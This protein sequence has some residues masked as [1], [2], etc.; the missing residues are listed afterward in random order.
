VAKE[1]NDM[2]ALAL[3][4]YFAGFL[5]YFEHNHAEMERLASDLIEMSTR[6]TF[7]TFLSVG[8]IL[9]GSAR[10][11]SGDST[12]G[13]SWIENGIADYRPSGS[14]LSMPYFLA[15]KAEALHLADRSSVALEAVS[16]AEAMVERR[17]RHAPKQPTQNTAGKKRAGQEDVDPDYHCGDCLQRCTYGSRVSVGVPANFVSKRGPPGSVVSGNTRSL[18]QRTTICQTLCGPISHHSVRVGLPDVAAEGQLGI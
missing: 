2:H 4:L 16:E 10:S 14:I 13:V 1:L 9:R 12:E 6:Q 8:A 5:A 17:W 15:L 18:V 11:A 7:A 3:A